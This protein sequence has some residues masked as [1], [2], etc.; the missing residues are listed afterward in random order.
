[1]PIHAFQELQ[2][3]LSS[4][5]LCL[6]YCGHPVLK[7]PG[8]FGETSG[9][10][11][12][13]MQK[14]HSILRSQD[15]EEVPCLGSHHFGPAPSVFT[16]KLRSTC[17]R[18][19]TIA[20]QPSMRFFAALSVC[21]SQRVPETR[22]GIQGRLSSARNVA[23]KLLRFNELFRQNRYKLSIIRSTFSYNLVAGIIYRQVLVDEL[24]SEQP[25]CRVVQVGLS[26]S[27]MFRCYFPS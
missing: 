20:S 11:L 7:D 13:K 16:L 1:M 23:F 14:I 12:N 10:I 26:S 27:S 25:E 15:F 4:S 2:N 17:L 5:Q 18:W 19:E 3:S 24:K 21:G 9:Q 8:N 6:P 22:V